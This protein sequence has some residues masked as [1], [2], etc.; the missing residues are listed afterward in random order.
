[1][2]ERFAGFWFESGSPKFLI[3]LIRKKP[4]DY[5]NLKNLEIHEYML[6]KMDLNDIMIEPLLFQTG[7]LTIKEIKP[8]WGALSYLVE[9]PNYEVRE[10]FNLQLISALTESGDV[11][12]WHAFRDIRNALQTGN[13]HVM[14]EI[15]RGLFASIPYELHVNAEAYYHSIF[16]ALLTLLGFDMNVEVSTSRGRID[17][18]LELED[19]AYIMEFKYVNC[20]TGAS[21]EEKKNLFNTALD[22]AME[23]INDRGYGDKYKGSGKTIYKAAFAFLGRDEIEMR[24]LM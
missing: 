13:L 7:Y 5:T 6:D 1:M 8:S 19:N 3:D 18:V 17:A 24:V 2:Q 12:T 23:Q 16:Y 10:A 22:N 20:P 15:L 9:M 4:G 21:V 11:R 14:L